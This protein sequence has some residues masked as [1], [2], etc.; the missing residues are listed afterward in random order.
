MRRVALITGTSHGLGAALAA[1]FRQHGVIV[2]G[3]SR[4]PGTT[5]LDLYIPGDVTNHNDRLRALGAVDE[6]FGRLDLLVNNAGIGIYNC[7]EELREEEL[8]AMF[9]V[10]FFAPVAL[11]KEALGMLRASRGTI[12][13][14]SSVAGKIHLPYMGG[15]NAT[16]F[17]LNAFSD[18]LRAELAP[19]GIHLLNLIVGRIATGFGTRPGRNDRAPKTP[20]IATPE[21]FAKAT[22]RAYTKRQRELV[23]PSWYRP[24]IWV[25]KM[26]PNLYDKASLKPWRS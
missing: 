23:F 14:V 2:A 10:N 22:W 19:D 11:T 5:P 9:E 26:V 6:R 15:Y 17:A 13:N 20:G 3:L 18:S 25:A 7:W 21:A 8:R 16:K 1:E 12:I 24:F 4:T